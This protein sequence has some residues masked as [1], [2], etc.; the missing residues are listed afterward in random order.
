VS[1]FTRRKAS[2]EAFQC[3]GRWSSSLAAEIQFLERSLCEEE[4]D[5]Y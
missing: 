3:A 1:R 2:C 4:N 5:D